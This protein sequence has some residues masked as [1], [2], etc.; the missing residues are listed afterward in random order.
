MS[1][2]YFGVVKTKEVV[3]RRYWMVASG[4]D[5]DQSPEA[6]LNRKV[7]KKNGH[8]ETVRRRML[9]GESR[10]QRRVKQKRRRCRKNCFLQIIMCQHAL[11]L[12]VL[13][14]TS[15]ATRE[16]KQ[17]EKVHQKHNDQDS[18]GNMKETFSRKHATHNPH[19]G[20]LKSSTYY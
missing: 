6:C 7:Q 17:Q 9:K 8:A 18:K 16:H 19:N 4:Y 14:S 15:L 12:F 3:T 10:Q 2:V 1:C 13:L 11:H 20:D 5:Y